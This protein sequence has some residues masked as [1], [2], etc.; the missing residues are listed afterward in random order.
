MKYIQ[1]LC[2]GSPVIF[3]LGQPIFCFLARNAIEKKWKAPHKGS[4]GEELKSG[5]FCVL[6]MPSAEIF[7]IAADS[8]ADLVVIRHKTAQ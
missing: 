7:A 8:T 5:G 3:L 2:A 1:G 6:A 4:R